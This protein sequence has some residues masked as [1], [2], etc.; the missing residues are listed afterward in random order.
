MNPFTPEMIGKIVRVTAAKR[1]PEDVEIAALLEEVGVLATYS[2][3]QTRLGWIFEH[4][5]SNGYVYSDEY[6][7]TVEVLS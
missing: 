4:S 7:L 6:D 5:T 2:E 1:I 3:T